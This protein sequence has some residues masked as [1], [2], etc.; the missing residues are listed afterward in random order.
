MK[1][2]KNITGFL[3]GCL[4]G[5]VDVIPMILQKLTWDANI[6]AF[7]MWAG[8]GFIISAV[9]LKIKGALKGLVV[10]FIMVLPVLVLVGWQDIRNIIP[11]FIMTAILGSLLG[12]AEG[13]INGN[14]Q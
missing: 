3:L 6:S 13:K 11:I 5:I 2:H 9:N 1:I 10:S 14:K 4:A 12:Y 7:C 8:A